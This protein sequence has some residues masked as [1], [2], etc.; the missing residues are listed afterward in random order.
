LIKLIRDVLKE[1]I[2]VK[3]IDYFLLDEILENIS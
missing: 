3:Y 2:I 1:M